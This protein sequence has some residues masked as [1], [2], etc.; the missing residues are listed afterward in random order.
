MSAELTLSRVFLP[1]VPIIEDGSRSGSFARGAG[2]FSSDYIT[3]GATSAGQ[4]RTSAASSPSQAN[5]PAYQSYQNSQERT[6]ASL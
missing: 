5:R 3:A 4:P 6:E 1:G 2:S